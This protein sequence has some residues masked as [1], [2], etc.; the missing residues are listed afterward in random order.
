MSSPPYTAIPLHPLVCPFCTKD[1]VPTTIYCY[2][3]ASNTSTGL[4][5]LHQR[6]CLHYH[7]PL[8]H[9]IHCSDLFAPK[10]M[11]PPPYTTIPLHPLISPFCTKDNVPTI[12][13]HYST[14]S[15]GLTFC[16]SMPFGA[17]WAYYG[18]VLVLA[19][20]AS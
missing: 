2:S 7:I 3:T 18:K 15:T 14:A 20:A 13:Y 19:S 17:A 6:L 1:N 16:N 12:I 11:S 8:F 9:C 10:T 4:T 5:L